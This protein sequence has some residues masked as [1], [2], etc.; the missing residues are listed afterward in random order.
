MHDSLSPPTLEFYAREGC[1][2][3][4]ET[5]VTLQHV[6]EQRVLRGDPVPRIREIDLTDHPDLE[7]RYGPVLPVLA[8]DGQQLTLA[9]GTRAIST[10]LDRTMGRAA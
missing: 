7:P 9:M 3:C 6:L 10:F 5:R 4:D 8:L 1:E 2:L